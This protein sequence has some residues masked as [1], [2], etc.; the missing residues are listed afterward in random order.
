[1]DALDV[2]RGEFS[3]Q[4]GSFLLQLRCDLVWDRAAFTRLTE[5]MLA[6][7]RTRSDE[8]TVER[9]LADGFWYLQWFTR[10]WSSNPDF[11]R[12]YSLDYYER[13]YR[14][15][16]DLASWFFSGENPYLG[17]TGFEPLT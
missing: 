8:P 9:W 1:M 2:L 10:E 12:A 13:A 3:A 14:R 17:E 5:A 7:C 15:L 16:D 6:Y 4:E 11:P